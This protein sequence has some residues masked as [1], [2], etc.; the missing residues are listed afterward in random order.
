LTAFFVCYNILSITPSGF[1]PFLLII[2]TSTSSQSIAPFFLDPAINISPELSFGNTKPNL[3]LS[4]YSP[5]RISS[6]P[7]NISI[8]IASS[9]PLNSM[10]SA[11]TLSPSLAPFLLFP[12]TKKPLS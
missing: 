4:L 3:T 6:D 9:F 1:F 11:L 10:I 12:Y 8:T 7:P 2:F 5:I